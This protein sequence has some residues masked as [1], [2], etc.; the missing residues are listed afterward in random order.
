MIIL[1]VN[2]KLNELTEKN[3]INFRLKELND[4]EKKIFN[5]RFITMNDF[6][7]DAY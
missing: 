2:C 7:K 1:G 3:T 5:I 6:S 4:L